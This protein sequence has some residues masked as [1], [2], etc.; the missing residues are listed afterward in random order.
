MDMEF[1]IALLKPAEWTAL[2]WALGFVLAATNVTKIIFRYLPWPD[3]SFTRTETRG[4]SFLLGII[5]AFFLWP[6]TS[7]APWWLAGIVLGP[8]M[9]IFYKYAAIIVRWKFPGL[10]NAINAERSV[11][12]NRRKNKGDLLPPGVGDDRRQD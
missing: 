8:A 7:T 4:I 5:A 12:S 6:A 1:I 10:W 2:A 11:L 9:S 3:R